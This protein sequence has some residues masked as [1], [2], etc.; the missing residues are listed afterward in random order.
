MCTEFWVGWFD[1]WG[2]GG[3]M[4]G[5]L[6]QSVK[7]LDKM[8]ELGHVNIYMFEGGTNFGFMN[9]SN[10]YDELTPDVTS[11]DYDA[12][13]TE[14]GQI[15]EK[16]NRYKEVI[17]KYREIPDVHF[18]TKITRKAYGHITCAG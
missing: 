15:T 12:V 6:E 1:H 17:Q 18:S 10:Y 14:D 2:N 5:D 9:G 4:R 13:L 7:D 8:L 3:H 11:Y 16:Y